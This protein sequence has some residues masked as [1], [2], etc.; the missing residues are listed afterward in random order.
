MRKK[1]TMNG[2]IAI[3]EIRVKNRK[4]SKDHDKCLTGQMATK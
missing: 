1:V 3:D 2:G 4:H